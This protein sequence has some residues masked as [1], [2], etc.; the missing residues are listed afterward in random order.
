MDDKKFTISGMASL[1]VPLDDAD[2]LL[3]LSDGTAAL[4]YLYA[5]RNGGSFSLK[6]AAIKLGRT[7]NEI[8]SAAELLNKSGLFKSGGQDR[9]TPPPADE[10]PEYTSKEIAARSEESGEFEAILKETERL[11]GHTLTGADMRLL[12][13]IYDHL[14]LPAEVILMLINHCE[15][16]AKRRFGPSGLPSMRSIEKEAYIWFNREILTLE[17][18][19]EYLQQKRRRA[20]DAE[21]IKAILQ[22]SG[23]N[24][25]TTERK[26]V[27]GWLDMGF[28]P[29]AIAI[30]YDRTVV[31]TGSL[32]WKYMNSILLSWHE[33]GLYTAEQVEEGDIRTASKKTVSQAAAQGASSNVRDDSELMR[34]ILSKTKS[35]DKG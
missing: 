1:A 30:A 14:R 28:T 21:D 27:E 26:Y 7:E 18:A 35:A 11:M 6:N 5:L 32:V 31:K 34:K 19:E 8:R 12:F 20:S 23:R 24:Y 10:L 3:D 29:E 33:K 16:E 2:R 25:S 15:E 4:L 22:I 9:S 17:R 13:G